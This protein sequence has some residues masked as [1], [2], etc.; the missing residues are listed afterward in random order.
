VIFLD[1][2]AGL[3]RGKLAAT[4]I[5]CGIAIFMLALFNTYIDLKTPIL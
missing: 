3:K 2:V 1:E 4:F 5:I